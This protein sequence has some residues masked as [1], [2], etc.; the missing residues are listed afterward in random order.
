MKT[1]AGRAKLALIDV[2]S[3]TKTR[4][5]GMPHIQV[6][7]PPK[8]P[9]QV[10]KSKS[11]A[12]IRSSEPS[13]AAP[14]SQKADVTGVTNR[15]SSEPDIVSSDAK[16]KP[17]SKARTD[18][19]ADAKVRP[20]SKAKSDSKTKSDTRSK[21]EA[22]SSKTDKK[23]EQKGSGSTKPTM[24]AEQSKDDGTTI[25]KERMESSTRESP[26]PPAKVKGLCEYIRTYRYM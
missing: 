26:T 16:A 21:V 12:T 11:K 10:S 8:P 13:K 15:L 25:A 9:L 14:R 17:D 19:K 1:L 2:N 18:S 4:V 23:S 22:K 7:A 5:E 6:K 3:I 20:D 24:S